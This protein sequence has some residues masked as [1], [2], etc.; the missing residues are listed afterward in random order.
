MRK[1]V[2]RYFF[3]FIESQQKWLNTMAQKG[4][5]LISTGKLVYEFEVCKPSE[6]QYYVDFVADKSDFKLNKYKVFLKEMG[7]K[8]FSK[9]INLNWSF[10][11]VTYRPYGEGM[12]KLA[13]SPGTYNKEIL[14]VEKINDGK[15]FELHT[16]MDDKLKYYKKQR[17]A[18]LTLLLLGAILF[19]TG[20]Y[21]SRT[22]DTGTIT[23]LALGILAAIPSLLLQQKLWKAKCDS[24]ISE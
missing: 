24:N 17:N 8:V 16:T 3:G 9:N 6:F 20:W 2:V 5:R 13:T 12:G 21:K 18:C 23:A 22:F 19:V 11:K 10:G 15:P 1:K 7:Y 14:I 4:Y